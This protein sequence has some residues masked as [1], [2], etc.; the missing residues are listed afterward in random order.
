MLIENLS[1]EYIDSI[2][3]E[4]FSRAKDD[5]KENLHNFFIG[6]RREY[7]G[8]ACAKVVLDCE[9]NYAEELAITMSQRA[10]DLLSIYSG[11]AL[12]PD[13]KNLSRIKGTEHLATTTAI[14]L[15]ESDG[16]TTRDGILETGSARQWM[17][18]NQSLSNFRKCGLDVVS[19]L[20]TQTSRTDFESMLLNSIS[21]Y[22]KASLT[23]EPL[24]KLVYMLSALETALLKNENEPI[25]QNLSERIALF[26]GEELERRK[27]IVKSVRNVY[28]IRSK[29]LHHGNSSSEL[30][31]MSVFFGHVWTFFVLLLGCTKKYNSKV[32][33][34]EAIDDMKL[35]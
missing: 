5:V 18:S 11:A 1:E 33:F 4:M 19:R 28:G 2:E 30:E 13:V 6:L 9:Y 12:L 16:I 10:L 20:V 24:E 3:K 32:Q 15:T 29:Y 23:A 21:I 17:I 34:L 14:F 35:T 25:Q 8:N 31:E 22:S 26:I 27:A 7:Q